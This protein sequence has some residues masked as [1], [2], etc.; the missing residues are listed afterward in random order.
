MYQPREGKLGRKGTMSHLGHS[1]LSSSSSPT[2]PSSADSSSP[3]PFPFPLHILG[4]LPATSFLS[5][6][7]FT[8]ASQGLTWG[9]YLSH[10]L[11][12]Q[13]LLSPAE[14]LC[15]SCWGLYHWGLAENVPLPR[16]A[17][18]KGQ[19]RPDAGEHFYT[20]L[21]EVPQYGKGHLPYSE[22]T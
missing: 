18:G 14:C 10:S 2:N 11:H 16:L 7:P 8:P 12:N 1:S 19:P 9:V 21:Q 20:G 3:I 17:A 4:T 5:S 15:S 13:H 22:P 6:A